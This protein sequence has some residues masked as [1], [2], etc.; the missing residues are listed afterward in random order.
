[1]EIKKIAV[2]IGHSDEE[3]E[4]IKGTI[5][6]MSELDVVSCLSAIGVILEE[7]SKKTGMEFDTMCQGLME[8]R[9]EVLAD[10]AKAK[11]HRHHHRHHHRTEK[12]EADQKSAE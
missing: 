7:Q 8:C 2:Q 3:L 11:K 12:P 1:M 10:M 4:L 9:K 5:A 6:F